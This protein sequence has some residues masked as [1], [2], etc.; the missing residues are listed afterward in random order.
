M[1]RLEIIRYLARIQNQRLCA[2]VAL[3]SRVIHP[4]M[5]FICG[6]EKL[7][8]PFEPSEKSTSV[9]ENAIVIHLTCNLEF[10]KF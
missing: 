8:E 5:K 1:I 7:M 6:V 2:R 4:R 9:S 3:Y 10:I